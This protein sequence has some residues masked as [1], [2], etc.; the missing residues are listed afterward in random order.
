M[1]ALH[2]FKY[3]IYLNNHYLKRKPLLALWIFEFSAFLE[4]VLFSWNMRRFKNLTLKL[5]KKKTNFCQTV[6]HNIFL[7]YEK[8][9]E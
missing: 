1:F 7:V 9:F 4:I 5:E 2:S 8:L 6:V 3:F